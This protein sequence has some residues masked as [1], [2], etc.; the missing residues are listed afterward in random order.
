[1]EKFKNLDKEKKLNFY[2][3]LIS[4]LI[5]IFAIAHA[6]AIS[7]KE[8]FEDYLKNYYRVDY[9]SYLAN[10]D[11]YRN[12]IIA[13]PVM[14]IIYTIYSFNQKEFGLIYKIINC[15]VCFSLQSMTWR[16][17]V[18]HTIYSNLMLL[19]FV[20]LF[21]LIIMRTRKESDKRA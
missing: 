19:L 18:P 6:S 3:L 11:S 15:Y 7:N 5:I 2:I 12:S 9:S 13:Y 4:V 21:A 14:L 10:I 8:A 17:F 16:S 1:M 20:I